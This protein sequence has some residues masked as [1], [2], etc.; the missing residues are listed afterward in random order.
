M[1]LLLSYDVR[2]RGGIERLTLQVAASLERQGQRVRLL[3]PR[4]LGPGSVGRW[5]GRARF[6]LELIRWLPQAETVLS[7]HAHLLAP[8]GLLGT[9]RPKR[10]GQ[11][12]RRFCWL[13]GIEVWGTALAPLSAGLRSCGGLV[14]SSSFTRDRL[15]EQP[16]PWPPVAV[17]HPMADPIGQ[18]GGPSPPPVAMRLLTVARMDSRELYKGHRLV[19]AALHLLLESQRLPADLLWSVVGEGDDRAALERA[20]ADLGLDPWVRFRGGLSDGE[21]AAELRACSLMVMPSAYGI[22]PNG[23]A[24]GEGFG[25]AYLEA[26]LAGRASIACRLGGQSDLIVDGET[27]WLIDPEVDQLAALLSRLAADPALMAR[28]GER[29]RRRALERFSPAC[30]DRALAEAL[31]LGMP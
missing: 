10:G 17:V 6:L 24:C 13:H 5:L 4:R 20:T 27:G 8:L 23:R 15:L 21:L 1:I 30:F 3:Y 19:L 7:M 22:E 2:R 25:I 12:G 9:W 18:E 31:Q 28:A 26:A 11:Q 29:A 16:G 14:A